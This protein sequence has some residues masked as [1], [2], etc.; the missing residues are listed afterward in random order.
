MLLCKLKYLHRPVVNSWQVRF[1]ENTLVFA[2]TTH[3]LL[4][5]VRLHWFKLLFVIILPT[6]R[7]HCEATGSR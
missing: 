4:G 6:H 3:T 2:S 1:D 7:E 5:I